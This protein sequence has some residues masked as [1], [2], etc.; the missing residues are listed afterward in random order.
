MQGRCLA[1]WAPS[2][3]SGG[4]RATLKAWAQDGEVRGVAKS[5][6]ACKVAVEVDP[7]LP[8]GGLEKSKSCEP[9]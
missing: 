5:L 4:I 6:G 1:L 2:W 9:L 3:G 7:L 8:K